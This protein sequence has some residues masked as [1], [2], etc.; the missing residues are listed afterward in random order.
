MRSVD[1]VGCKVAIGTNSIDGC[2]AQTEGFFQVSQVRFRKRS[3]IV[4]L[5]FSFINQKITCTS[6]N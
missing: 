5:R 1:S 6:K 4:D 2:V 3:R